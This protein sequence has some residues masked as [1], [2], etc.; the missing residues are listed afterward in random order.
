ML[1]N[2]A[3]LAY[4]NLIKN[5]VPSFINLVG[6]SVAV[7]CAIVVYLFV[8]LHLHMDDFHEDG[9]RIF[10]V[11]NIIDRDG[12]LQLWGDAPRPLG[13]M[14]EADLPQVEKAVRVAYGGATFQV[15]ETVLRDDIWYVD[16]DFLV[17]LTFPL[18]YGEPTALQD[19][20]A[21][22]ISEAVAQKYFGEANPV[23]REI[24]VRF[25]DDYAD[26]FV[27]GGVAEP[28]PHNAS[29]RFDALVRYDTQQRLG[30]DLEDWS[31]YTGA[32]FLL[33]NAPGDIDAVAAQMNKYLQLQNAASDDWPIA[34][35]RFD[36]LYNLSWNS[37]NVQGDISGG[38][39]PAAFVVFPLVGIFLLVLSC[40]NYMNI[41]IATAARR[42]KEIGVR[43]VVGSKRSQ[44]I[45]QFLSENVLLCLIA[46]GVG[47]VLAWGLFV[48]GFNQLFPDGQ[49]LV[50]DFGDN[51]RL[52]GFL[53]VLVV[54]LGVVSGA[55]PAF[56]ISS[57][58]PIDI[59]RGQQ[60]LGGGSRLTQGLLTFQFVLA[61]LT[62]MLGVVLTLNGRYQQSIDW[63]YN[64]EHVVGLRLTD[65][66]QY[67]MLEAAVAQ[68][69]QALEVVGSRNHIGRSRYTAVFDV[70][71]EKMEAKGFGVG[72]GYLEALGVRLK[73]GRFF[74]EQFGADA[75]ESIIVNEHFVA[76]RG[77]DQPLGQIMRD[78]TLQYTV[79]GVVAD[80]HYDDFFDAIEPAFF[81]IAPE[82]EFR[83]LSVRTEAGGG[84]QMA[85]F[86]EE[87]W[88][89]LVPDEA[90]NG[91]FQ[92]QVFENFYRENAN[93][94]RLF[95]FIALLALIIA[96]MGL[97]GLAAQNIARRMK[98][99][100]I[101][102][103]LGATVLHVT[104]LV[105]RRFLVLL[106]LAAVIAT[107]VSYFLLDALLDS[108]YQYRMDLNVAP[109]FVS[110]VL[111]LATAALT[112]SL[113]IRRL[114]TANPAE[115]L[116][117][118]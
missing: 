30:V 62:M 21:V 118:E 97:F 38:S 49:S 74:D 16:E 82:D 71:G 44:L 36:N 60:Q 95:G 111:V 78:D 5:K 80:L 20:N 45:I 91:F 55:Y 14:I 22:I 51:L 93:I 13:P 86:L 90:Y 104:S 96:C 47:M 34:E 33:L 94:S 50:M 37:F 114:A 103:V 72:Y 4:R 81:R 69:P 101:R 41:A 110:Y 58:I 115:V 35:F 116:R 107:P 87:T 53:V 109:F 19:P 52:W 59:L 66:S 83:Y 15:G 79:V 43:K 113:L 46:L 8:D 48:P 56:Y 10:L 6:L 65:P 61:F 68:N 17:V 7:G 11:E 54:L 27:V 76:A 1:K 117:N 88:K 2:Y 77:W 67:P 98:E 112:I 32:T 18:R 26:V 105:N 89:Q 39:H 99:I 12:N 108:I 42:L 9:E 106:A 57:F 24:N 100:S 31:A 85:A 84:V 75:S 102:K 3:K 92:D 40:F 64:Q 63:G 73:E 23:G 29:F 28:F 25:N 70:E